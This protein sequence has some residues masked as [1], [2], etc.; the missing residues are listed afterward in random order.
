MW[1]DS[2]LVLKLAIVF[3]ISM[4]QESASLTFI[5]F[6]PIGSSDTIDVYDLTIVNPW[7]DDGPVLIFRSGGYPDPGQKQFRLGRDFLYSCKLDSSQIESQFVVAD[8][9]D[10]RSIVSGDFDSDGNPEVLGNQEFYLGDGTEV[11][12]LE[13]TGEAWKEYREIIPF[14]IDAHFVG[15]L[16]DNQGDDFIFA[17]GIDTITCDTC[18]YDI[19]SSPPMG[20][21]YGNRDDEKL[22]MHVDSTFHYALQSLGVSF[23]ETTYVYSYE[24]VE[25]TASFAGGGPL[26]IGSIVKYRFDRDKAR[27]EKLYYAAC[28]YF[29]GGF[30]HYNG[31]SVY[32]KDSVII[33]LD[34]SAVQWF[35]DD[36]KS[37]TLSLIQYTPFPCFAPVLFD[38]DGDGEDDLIC[39]EPQ[40]P[41]GATQGPNWM[42]K[43]YKILK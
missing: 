13:Y 12:V 10:T 20:L 42:I 18:S 41:D 3:V 43:A 7:I 25:D 9:F 35:I 29:G 4:A 34:D 11:T 19:E 37:L 38:I 30:T 14:D 31:S 16:F 5:G 15:D 36:G 26:Y 17:F 8:S 6:E 40:A 32:A 22:N 24:A 23:G 27:L 21:I 1:K 39:T 28:P 33:I 2:R